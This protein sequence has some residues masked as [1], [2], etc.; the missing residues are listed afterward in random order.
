MRFAI[1]DS[2]LA[3]DRQPASPAY[4]TVRQDHGAITLRIEDRRLST[5]KR[6]YILF[7]SRE[8][9][10]TLN[11]VPIPLHY[12]YVFVA[13]A[14][15]GMFTITGLAGSY[16]RMLIK[17]ARFNQLRQDHQSLQKDYATL[18]KQAHQKDVQAASLGSLATEVSALYGLTAGKI[19]SL[20]VGG[21]PARP[22][23]TLVTAATSAPLKDFDS[24]SFNN[25]SYYKS[26]DAF[27]ALRSSA[28][29][30]DATRI[31]AAP[32][33]LGRMMNPI[34]PGHDLAGL[35]YP[36]GSLD[37]ATSEIPTLW[38][39][40]GPITSSF[41]ERE[42]PF[43]G[44]NDEGEFHPGIDISGP[45]GTP[46][47]ATADGVV[48]AAEVVNG[49]GREVTIDHGHGL[50]TLYG[51]MSGFAVS[52]GQSVTRG[53]VIGYIGHTGR[54]TGNHVHYE[55]RIHNTPVNPHKYLRTTLADFGTSPAVP[56]M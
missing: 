22:S 44:G 31:L 33:N 5:K 11:K 35:G 53:Q 28:L 43:G 4:N 26:V 25:D 9:D 3:E 46:I 56:A 6:F 17:T 40:T 55:V 52:A 37:F 20:H 16:T 50:E 32:P 48:V 7:V 23:T 49:Y 41:G 51:H 19:G 29:D 39:V 15:I 30:G 13:A 38:P 14:A 8:P 10:G 47:H 2:S 12:A 42:N 27:Y 34:M 54:T 24:A 21:N 1:P 36:G 18:E 45:L